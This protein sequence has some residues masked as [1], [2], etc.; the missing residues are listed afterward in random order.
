MMQGMDPN[1]IVPLEAKLHG[2]QRVRALELRVEA[3]EKALQ[4]MRAAQQ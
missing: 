3:L 2:E 4:E 1:M